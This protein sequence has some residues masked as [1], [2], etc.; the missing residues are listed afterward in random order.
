MRELIKGVDYPAALLRP[1]R[2]NHYR[3]HDLEAIAR[4]LRMGQWR[5]IG[6]RADDPENPL[7]G[8]SIIA[9]RG[10]FLAKTKLLGADVVTATVVECTEEEA[11]EAVALDNRSHELG[12]DDPGLLAELLG[13]I[14]ERGR[15]EH[16]GYTED[17]VADLLEAARD[18]AGARHE[19]GEGGGPAEGPQI[20]DDA[21]SVPPPPGVPVTR[22]GDVWLLG[23]H[24]LL[25][26]DA[27]V[28]ADVDRALGGA[29]AAMVLTDPPYAIYG[30]SSGVSTDV[31]DDRMVRPFFAQLWRAVA[32]ILPVFGHAYVH[33]DW[34]SYP[35][36]W[37][38]ARGTGM[39]VRN[40]L[41]WDKGHFGLGSNYAN[42]YELVAFSA[43]L[44][45][46]KTM[47][48]S[49]PKG[50]R[51]VHRPNLLRYERTSGADR[52]HNA[53]KPVALL[54]E[55]V[56]NSSDAGDLV[57]DLFAGSGSTLVAAHQID[58]RAVLV[59]LEPQWC[60]VICRRFETLTGIRPV[61][62][63]AGEARSFVEAPA[64]AAAGAPA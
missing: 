64:P 29:T 48:A 21:D 8:G 28:E 60:D 2:K 44:P 50:H 6:V 59:E 24:R 57:V 22:P 14:A 37:E 43:R 20:P 34:R 10:V 7:A 36:L 35:T 4:G 13:G 47:T 61:L 27:F 46:V 16:V 30:S 1:H 25:C 19:G 51:Q 23:E 38:A 9:G 55:L 52:Q 54:A 53:A 15:L 42:N 3:R 31:A 26:G 40:L 62:A 11:E 17:D 18:D 63:E 5:S 33:C 56:G 49:A 45:P 32:R 58:R 39:G 41:V 12:D